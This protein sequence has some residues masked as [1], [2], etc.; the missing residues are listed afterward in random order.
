MGVFINAWKIADLRKKMLFTIFIIIIFRL[1]S[2]IFVPFI[3]PG[4][5][6]A[7][8]GGDGTLF[9]TFDIITGGG[10]GRGTLFAMSIT[11]YINAS[12]IMQLLTV[13][14]PALERMQKEGEEGQKKINKIIKLLAL[15]IGLFQATA[16][17]FVLANMRNI[18]VYEDGVAV[19][20]VPYA[21]THAAGGGFYGFIEMIVI[22]GC[23]TA[24]ASLIIWLG[25][26]ITD[27]GIGNGISMVL[28]AGIMSGIP[29]EIIGLVRQVTAARGWQD[30]V[31]VPLILAIYV[32]M[33]G[34]VVH[35]TNAERRIPVQYAKRQVGRKMYGGQSSHIPIKVAMSGVMPIIFAMS[36][37]T[38]PQTIL[39]FFGINHQTATGFWRRFF[40]VF[41]STSWI[42]AFFYFLLIIGFNYF[43]VA[44]QYNP[45]EIANN[46]KKNNGAIPGYRPGKPTSDFIHNSLSKVTF[47]GAIFL[48]IVAIFPIAFTNITRYAGAGGGQGIVGLSLGGTTVLIVVGVALET[49]R[50]L[51]SQM[52]MRH[53]KGFL[54]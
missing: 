42:Y 6:G 50:T 7:L 41:N 3:T 44:V 52:M 9:Q 19:G 21:L 24:G 22:I 46:L 10:L 14:I 30:V 11:P 43:Y 27:K 35:M 45:V 37:M 8:L 15:G 29:G 28:F 39:H 53:H 2:H 25:E 31:F 47:I 18:P 36:I 54:E 13:A 16:F 4:A 40:E 26:Q 38:L 49:I 34:F 23:F 1:G 48:G 5:M 20:T 51:E 17:Y 32:V 12:I 33:I